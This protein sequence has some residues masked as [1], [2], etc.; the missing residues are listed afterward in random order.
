MGH[1]KRAKKKEKNEKR[2]KKIA[3]NF[4]RNYVGG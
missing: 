1:E 2:L 4:I 3:E